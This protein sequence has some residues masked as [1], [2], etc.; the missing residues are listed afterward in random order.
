MDKRNAEPYGATLAAFIPGRPNLPQP[1]GKALTNESIYPNIVELAVTAGGLEVEL[2]RRIIE[3]HK[4][5]HT[6]PRH[7]R[8]IH[9]EHQTYYRWCFSDLAMARAF[10]EQ[11]GGS[12]VRNDNGKSARKRMPFDL[13]QRL[14]IGRT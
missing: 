7:G 13:N 4:L 9:S 2:A 1:Y 5:R 14:W 10:H 6:E 8:I 3:F 12:L 11:F